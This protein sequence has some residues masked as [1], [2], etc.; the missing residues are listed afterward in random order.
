MPYVGIIRSADDEL[1]VYRADFYNYLTGNKSKSE[2]EINV[3]EAINK[4]L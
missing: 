4:I 3:G 2:E 1:R